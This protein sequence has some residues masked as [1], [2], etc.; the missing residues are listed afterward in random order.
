MGKAGVENLDRSLVG[1]IKAWFDYNEET[2][3]ITWKDWISPD[4]YSYKKWHDTFMSERAGKRV[5]F[6][7]LR[8]GHLQVSVAGRTCV[9]AHIIVWVLT[10]GQ[11]PQNQIDH[12]D[13]DVLNNRIENLRDVPCHI[14]SRNKRISSRN[15]SG[16]T[17]VGWDKNSQKWR[18]RV[19]MY[20]KEIYLGAFDT[21]EEA[22]A[23]REKF[24]VEND[25][26]GF[27]E[28]HGK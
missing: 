5:E 20:R 22:A 26:L 10:Q 15:V 2:G 24:L 4:W 28:R 1:I 12:I 11:L 19:E 23:A 13:G 8:S 17:G 25:H 27:T 7:K 9:R 14:N 21:I 3:E 18:A 6:Y 16:V